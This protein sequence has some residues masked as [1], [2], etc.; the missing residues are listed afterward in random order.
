[1]EYYCSINDEQVD[2][3][4]TWKDLHELMLSEVSRTRRTLYIVTAM[5]NYDT[6]SSSQQYNDARQFQKT[7]DEKYYPH[8]EK[9]LWGLNTD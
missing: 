2:F 5:I 3:R 4:K 6:L 1:M 8:L 9:K 7:H